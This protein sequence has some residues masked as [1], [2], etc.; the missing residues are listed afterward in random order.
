MGLRIFHTSDLHLGMKFG[1][2]PEIQNELIEARFETLKKLVSL[3]NKKNCDLFVISGDLFNQVKV[4]KKDILRAVQII[5][6]FEGKLVSVLPGNHDFRTGLQDDLWT[7]F[8]SGG[9]DNILLLE[10]EE[11]YPLNVYDLNVVLYPAPCAKKHSGEN[12]IGWVGKAEKDTSFLHH[13]GVAHGSLAGFSPDFESKYYPMAE[14]ELHAAGLDMWL[15]GHTHIRYP[16]TPGAADRIFYPGTPEPDGFDCDHTGTAWILDV[17]DD[18]KITAN[19]VSCGIYSFVHVNLEI[20]T[21]EDMKELRQRYD[22]GSSG[23]ILMKVRLNGSL[24]KGDFVNLQEVRKALKERLLYLEWDSDEVSE[25]ITTDDIND[26]FTEGS[27]PHR[28]LMEMSGTGDL[29]AL[30]LAYDLIGEI[31]K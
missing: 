19:P 16:G 12:A 7:H 31:K 9:G 15:L 11:A 20:N 26:E 28:L 14:A 25:Q 2:Y 13:I 27:F 21:I 22:H 24:P 5:K 3:A 23:K 18:K 8:R 10:K 4:A 6:E 29:E 17:A 30:Q 1:G